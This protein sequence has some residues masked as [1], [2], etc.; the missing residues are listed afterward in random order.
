[1][2]S[3]KEHWDIIIKPRDN[4]F[5]L[6]LGETWKYRDLIKR[7]IH[8]DIV[9]AYKQTV[10]GPI[11]YIIQPLFTTI[12]YMFVFAGIAN[13]PTDGLPQPL[14]YLSGIL[15]WNYFA[16]C[17]GRAQ[18]TFLSNAGVFSKVYFP[19][20]VVPISGAIS[21]MLKLAIQVATFAVIYLYFYYAKGIDISPNIYILLF[22]LLILM[23]ACFAIG[24]GIIISSM[25]TKY[26]DMGI[27][28]SFL[29]SLWMYI[30][31]I[32]YPLSVMSERYSEYKWIIALNPL[33]PIV[34]TFRFAT[35]GTGEFSWA[36]LAYSFGVT[37]V[38]LI[39][40]I[41]V[42]NKVERNFIDVV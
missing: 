29:V 25:T 14:F 26:R 33:T 5:S 38:V 20:M 9:T 42:F 27:L 1:M 17:L 24:T 36:S 32:I 21:T 40:G 31:P 8:R 35:M 16:E 37:V 4:S 3:E 28:I 22:P 18:G 23:T 41:G 11:W 12:M 10:L 19:R 6:N 34:E 39:A 15:I 13:I 2:E 7:Y 30:T